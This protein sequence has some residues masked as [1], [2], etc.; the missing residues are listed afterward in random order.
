VA[1]R[2]TLVPEAKFAVQVDGQLIPAGVLMI[3]PLPETVTVSCTCFFGGGGVLDV[4]PPQP[5][6]QNKAPRST[7]RRQKR[8][9]VA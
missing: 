7:D 2:V 4:P 8:R 3:V 9:T 6:R 5:G 1:A